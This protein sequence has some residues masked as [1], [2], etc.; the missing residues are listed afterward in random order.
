MRN[1]NIGNQNQS[2]MEQVTLLMK[3]HHVKKATERKVEKKG[4]GRT[5]QKVLK[6][7]FG[8]LGQ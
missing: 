1:V 2:I 6:R 7:H 3:N 8:K 5:T 4:G